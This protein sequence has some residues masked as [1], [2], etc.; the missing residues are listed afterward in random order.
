VAALLLPLT[1]FALLL[2]REL[3]RGAER[4]PRAAFLRAAVGWG[5]ALL[6]GTE[7]LSLWEVLTPRLI[8]GYWAVATAVAAGLAW[9]TPPVAAA[10]KPASRQP[11]SPLFALGVPV[12]AVVLVTGA[13]ALVAW[14]NQWDTL[15]YH[16]ARV[17]HWM[18]NR[19]VAFYP[20]HIV[21][22]LASPPWAE[23]AALHL[24]SLG[25]DER[26]GNLVQWLGMVGS[27]IGVSVIARELGAGPT[28]QLLATLAAATIPMGV[29][30]AS[31]MQNDHVLA[32]WLVC[33]TAALVPSPP[34]RPSARGAP[35]AGAALGLALAT[36]GTAYVLSG[37]L[38]VLPLLVRGR[39]D[40]R[41]WAGRTILVLAVALALNV[42]HYARNLATFGFPLGPRRLGS[43][44]EA[45]DRLTNEALTPGLLFS[46]GVRNLSLHLALP[47]AAY[48]DALARAIRAAH[49]RLGLDVEDPRSTR[50][51]PLERFE[52]TGPPNDPSRTGNPLHLAVLAAAAATLVLSRRARGGPLVV[53]YVAALVLSAFLFCALLK[54]QPWHSRLHLPLFVLASALVGPALERRTRSLFLVA[55]AMTALALPPLLTSELRPLRGPSS[56]LRVD[57]IEQYFPHRPWLRLEYVAAAARVRALACRDVGLVL[58]WDDHEHPLWALLDS[59]PRGAVR[60]EH[61]GVTNS[62]RALASARPPFTPCALFGATH[63]VSSDVRIGGRGYV[64]DWIGERTVVLV[65]E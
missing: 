58:G 52:I 64:V 35:G 7:L 53:P 2:H 50:L 51:Y 44:F 61:V 26:A 9:R 13:L 14:P 4:D 33:L 24:V 27:L 6:A 25:G 55:V 59:D 60:I 31:T 57:R 54:W 38:L 47:W 63:V 1:C 11:R 19:S 28:G 65:P 20:T 43:A 17:D 3:R 30:Q 48:N 40:W 37:P 22:Q 18:Q 16:L 10:G 46:N 45:D 32:F 23:Y 34:A 5:V 39:R 8:A 56:V 15:V 42:P 21:R 41:G 36:K 49:D 12:A 29:L 62:S